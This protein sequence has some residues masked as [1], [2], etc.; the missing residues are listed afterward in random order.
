MSLQK[1]Q[2]ICATC[3]NPAIG[4]P[5]KKGEEIQA[6]TT[7]KDAL[8]E[9]R[10]QETY[11]KIPLEHPFLKRECPSCVVF[12]VF[13]LRCDSGKPLA[14]GRALNVIWKYVNKYF[15]KKYMEELKN[16]KP[17]TGAIFSVSEGAIIQ[18]NLGKVV[19]KY[20]HLEWPLEVTKIIKS[21]G[22]PFNDIFIKKTEMHLIEGRVS[23][24]FDFGFMSCEELNSKLPITHFPEDVWKFIMTF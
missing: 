10:Y 7:W 2:F 24:G 15:E 9:A 23:I 22:E 3:K 21:G 16:S 11:D 20:G 12:T 13:G 8:G 4:F 14:T 19:L 1:N 5:I 6:L 17:Q 18:V